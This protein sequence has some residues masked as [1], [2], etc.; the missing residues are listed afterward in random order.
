MEAGF[1]VLNNVVLFT[2]IPSKSSSESSLRI[3]SRY[4]SRNSGLEGRYLEL[5]VASM[6]E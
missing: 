1:L 4:S 5:G 2:D 6:I 3:A